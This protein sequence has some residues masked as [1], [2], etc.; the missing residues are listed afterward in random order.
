MSQLPNTISPPNGWV[1]NSNDWLYSAAGV[2]SPK[3]QNFPAYLDMAGESY[4][5]IHAQR[6]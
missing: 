3:P 2:D 5:T 6:L 1:F 4:R